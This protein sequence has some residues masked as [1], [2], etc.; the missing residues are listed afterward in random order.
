MEWLT[1]F[2]DKTVNIN[3][4]IQSVQLLLVRKIIPISSHIAKQK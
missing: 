3:K 2:F 1:R 4:T